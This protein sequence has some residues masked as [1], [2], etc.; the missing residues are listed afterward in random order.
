M[1]TTL[2][3]CTTK[4]VLQSTWIDRLTRGY[5]SHNCNLK[6]TRLTKGMVTI[7]IFLKGKSFLVSQMYIGDVSQIQIACIF[8][9]GWML[10][11]FIW[12]NISLYVFSVYTVC[13]W[14]CKNDTCHMLSSHEV[15]VTSPLLTFDWFMWAEGI[16]EDSIPFTYIDLP[17]FCL[18]GALHNV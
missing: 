16:K 7:K 4:F 5:V 17:A 13:L 2:N 11:P 8:Y 9:S 15:Y 18:S 1:Y 12:V 10:Q 14:Q 6:V 3:R